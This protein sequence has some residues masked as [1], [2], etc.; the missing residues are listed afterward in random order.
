M[1]KYCPNCGTGVE[2]SAVKCTNCGVS[3]AQQNTSAAMVSPVVNEPKSRL[4][5]AILALTFGTLGMHQ[6]YLGEKS[7][8]T[9][10]ILLSTVGTLLCG[11]GP[12]ASLI[13]AIVDAIS[14][15]SGDINQDGYGKPLVK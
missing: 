7:K 4:V 8:G 15:F 2:D 5:A 3:F 6:F 13:W 9:V 11:L 12:V 14:L 10:R 1:A